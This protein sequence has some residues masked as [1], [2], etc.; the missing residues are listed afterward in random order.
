MSGT[1]PTGGNGSTDASQLPA[2]ASN[3]LMLLSEAVI[4]GGSLLLEKKVAGGLGVAAGGLIGSA[5]MGAVFGPL[6][7]LLTRYGASA[8]S[9]A[10][11]VATPR[12]TTTS[13]AT[14]Q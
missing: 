12:T 1:S 14:T 6:G 7:F 10:S 3:G 8:L 5:L 11:A 2:I 13:V 4:P 9:Y